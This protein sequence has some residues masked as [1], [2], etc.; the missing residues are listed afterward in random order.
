MLGAPDFADTAGS[1][2]TGAPGRFRGDGTARGRARRQRWWQVIEAREPLA[3]RALRQGG[4]SRWGWTLATRPRTHQRSKR[5]VHGAGR[6]GG[7]GL[8]AAL[9]ENNPHEIDRRLW[10]DGPV[11]S[12]A[13]G[14]PDNSSGRRDRLPGSGARPPFASVATQPLRK[15]KWRGQAVQDL[16]GC[17]SRALEGTSAPQD[18][19]LPS[20]LDAV[21]FSA[22]VARTS[23]GNAK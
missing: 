21:D 9:V 15:R 14:T 10:S 17:E 20:I 12:T 3:R 11:A 22:S 5:S 8:L 6:L 2:R 13:A 4:V 18:Q 1:Y 7:A 16:L 23:A 19:N